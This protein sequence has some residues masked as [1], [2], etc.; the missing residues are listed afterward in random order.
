[1]VLPVLVHEDSFIGGAAERHE[2]RE[3]KM[4]LQG[5]PAGALDKVTHCV[6]SAL[7]SQSTVIGCT[8]LDLHSYKV[9]VRAYKVGW[10]VPIL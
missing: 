7:S 4:S 5:A 10:I 3:T 2:G 1:M 8:S 9:K 6:C